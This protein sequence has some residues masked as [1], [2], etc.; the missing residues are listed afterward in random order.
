[1][2]EQELSSGLYGGYTWIIMFPPLA[3][4]RRSNFYIFFLKLY[5]LDLF[6]KYYNSNWN[7]YFFIN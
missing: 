4:P 7:V 3:S 1:M 6:I 5:M 2:N